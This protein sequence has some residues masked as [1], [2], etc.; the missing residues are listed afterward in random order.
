MHQDIEN[1]IVQHMP[2]LRG[3]LIANA[4]LA[5]YSWLRVG[6]AAQLLFSPKDEDDLAYFLSHLPQNIPITPLGVGSNLIIRDG[7][8]KGVVIRLTPAFA[9]IEHVEPL[10]IKA[11]AAALDKKV[12]QYAAEH[13]IGGLSFLAGIPGTI[14]GALRMNAGAHG[15]ETKECFISA[16]AI[17][18]DGQKLNLSH[19]DMAFQYRYSAPA[20]EVIFTAALFQGNSKPTEEVRKEIAHIDERR[21]ATQPIRSRTAG[22]TFKNPLPDSAWKLIDKA[23]CRGLSYGGA[24]FSDMHCNFLLNNGDATAYD[25]EMLGEI[26]R[27]RVYEDSGILLEW[28]VKRI[29]L[30]EQGK[31]IEPFTT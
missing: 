11:G 12:A 5:P 1:D 6:G 7:G 10:M 29:G 19:E 15:K 25:L 21:L 16:T 28:E 9:K 13:S 2:D 26:V 3:R 8:I 17:A 27:K 22:S 23:G 31:E 20:K 24:Q 30:F 14:G 18:R 4:D